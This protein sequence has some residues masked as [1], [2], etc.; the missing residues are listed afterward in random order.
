M[1]EE[2]AG[3]G[4][5]MDSRPE[6]GERSLLHRLFETDLDKKDR[7][8]KVFQF[9][10]PWVIFTVAMVLTVGILTMW[11]SWDYGKN[12]L[13]VWIFYT[14]PPAG[15]E[16]IIP[17]VVLDIHY[18]V[19]GW[20]AGIS[21]SII[22][23]VVSLFLIWNYD[24]VKR[25]PVLGPALEK[26]EAKG[27]QKVAKSKWFRRSTFIM[28]TFFVF[29]PFSGSGGVGGT[30]FGRIVGMKPYRVLLAV[31]IGSTMGSTAFAI[32]AERL[33]DVLGSNNPVISFISN[34][35]MLQV[36]VVILVVGFLVYTVRNPKMAAIRT[37]KVVSQALD[38]SEKALE[39]A[40]KQRKNV[41]RA[42]IKGTKTT[43][44]TVGKVNRTLADINM[45]VATAPMYLMG[46]EGK[47][48]ARSTREATK[49]TVDD[50]HKAAGSAIDMTLDAGE[51]A[52]DVTFRTAKKLTMEGIGHTRKGWN[53]AGKVILKGGEQLEKVVKKNRKEDEGP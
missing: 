50:A 13:D 10:F 4:I 5:G 40:E 16:T 42:T 2:G 27:S 38:I 17:K 21:T 12:L 3:R 28:T 36:V 19:P 11:K 39:E 23:S 6:E 37:T 33:Q 53:E 35:N 51:Q 26:T 32:A 24:W 45:E 29:V 14:L 15:K 25:L 9:F 46:E 30:V 22:D 18:P 48:M 34:L 43:I 41:T 52:S 8:T 44:R 49:K 7:T 1:A 20:L 47:K 31:V